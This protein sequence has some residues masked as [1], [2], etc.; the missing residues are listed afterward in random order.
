ML[1]TKS[2][3]VVLLL[4]SYFSK[5]IIASRC[6]LYDHYEHG[7]ATESNV[8]GLWYLLLYFADDWGNE[9]IFDITRCPSGTSLAYIKTQE[10]W[11]IWKYLRCE[12]GFYHLL[13]IW[14]T[15]VHSK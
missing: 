4:L 12:I 11:D 10:D 5:L 9:L 13:V 8:N 2:L 3:Q 6:G 14:R 7:Y 15:D 1:V